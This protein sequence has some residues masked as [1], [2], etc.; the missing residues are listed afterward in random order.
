MKNYCNVNNWTIYSF[1]EL[2]KSIQNGFASGERDKNGIIQFRMNNVNCNAQMILDDYIRVP[3]ELFKEKYNVQRGDILFNHTNS[4]EMV[5]KS[6]VFNGYKEPVTFSNHFSRIR[7]FREIADPQFIVYYFVQLFHQRF[8]E[9]LCD[10]WIHQAAFQNE[11]IMKIPIALP[12]LFEQKR[13]VKIIES[14]FA[15][16]EKCEKCQIS[17]G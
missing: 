1:G 8:F 7:L 16:T 14:K 15:S 11:K 5:G 9:N 13:I 2:I 6:F 17:D 12:P 3:M 10:R 4:A